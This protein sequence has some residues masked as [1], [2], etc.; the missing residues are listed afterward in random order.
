MVLGNTWFAL[1]ACLLA[2]SHSGRHERT[3]VWTLLLCAGPIEDCFPVLAVRRYCGSRN[4]VCACVVCAEEEKQVRKPKLRGCLWS[5]RIWQSELM[6]QQALF[7]K[8]TYPAAMF[9]SR[10]VLPSAM[11]WTEKS[12]RVANL[13]RSHKHSRARFL[14]LLLWICC[15]IAVGFGAEVFNT[16]T[17]A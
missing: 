1:H 13:I 5:S 3:T 12:A 11:N 8:S 6:I 17:A 15:I 4:V 7:K 14:P 10:L 9:T 16:T 2:L